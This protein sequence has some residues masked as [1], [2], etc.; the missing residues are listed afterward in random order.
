MKLEDFLNTDLRDFASYSNIRMIASYA[1]GLKNGSRKIIYTILEKNIK[2]PLK[3]SQLASK[4]SEFSE[5]LHGETSLCG[6]IVTLAQNY[7]GA[8]NLPLLTPKGNFGTRHKPCAAASRYIFTCGSDTLFRL[9]NST[10]SL[11]VQPQEF[12]GHK[13]EP[14]FY[15][16]N[17]PLI[18]INGSDGIAEGFRQFI[19]PRKPEDIVKAIKRLLKDENADVSD[20]LTPFYKGFTG[21]ITKDEGRWKVQGK[22]YRSDRTHIDICELPIGYDWLTYRNTLDKLQDTKVIQSY[23]DMSDT[24]SD[25]FRFKV[26][27]SAQ[28]LD[29]LSAGQILDKLKLT[30]YYTENF[31]CINE[32]NSIQVFKSASDILKAWL[33]LKLAYNALRKEYQLRQLG[34]DMTVYQAKAAFIKAVIKGFKLHR[35]KREVEDDLKQLN[36]P[37]HPDYDYLLNMPLASLTAEKVQELQR[38]TDACTTAINKLKTLSVKD[39]LVAD[40][41]I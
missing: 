6:S 13:I 5:Y 37:R 10:D 29:R 34:D 38:K 31:V 3:V 9:F 16:P 12:E 23:K 17:L 27:M 4:V 7:V 1:D 28:E 33:K 15:I 2:D 36:L 39:M 40:M 24:K 41:E 32:N 20:L 19:L 21:Q 30:K 26:S 25:T 11:L 8:N 18:L 22:I 14:K 35:P